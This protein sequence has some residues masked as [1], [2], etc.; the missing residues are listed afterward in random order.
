MIKIHKIAITLCLEMKHVGARTDEYELH[1]ALLNDGRRVKK[2]KMPLNN[3]SKA[4]YMKNQYLK[5]INRQLRQ[6]IGL[7]LSKTSHPVQ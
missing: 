5:Q 7:F 3:I 6:N 1:A 4:A 2:A